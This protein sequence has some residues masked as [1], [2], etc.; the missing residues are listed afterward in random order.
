MI[1]RFLYLSILVTGL[2]SSCEKVINVNLDNAPNQIV[3]EGNI[4]NQNEVQTI[5][6]SMFIRQ[7]GV[8]R[9]R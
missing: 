4:T 5:K 2:F 7:F 1:K 9:L 3:I 6:I 8:L